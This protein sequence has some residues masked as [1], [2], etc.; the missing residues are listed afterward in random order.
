MHLD[1]LGAVQHGGEVHVDAGR[2]QTLHQAHPA[3]GDGGEARQDV[4]PVL[5]H[6]AQFGRIGG[7]GAGADAEVV[8]LNVLV[9]PAESAGDRL[10]RDGPGNVDG[11]VWSH[12][13]TVR[14][15]PL[16]MYN[17]VGPPGWTRPVLVR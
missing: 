2:R 16:A 12:S 15:R 17:A 13:F 14:S 7:V 6:V 8:K 5:Q 11:H 3:A 9:V 10:G 4:Q 1:P